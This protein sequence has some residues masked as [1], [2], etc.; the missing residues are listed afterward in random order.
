MPTI[1]EGA[2]KVAQCDSCDACF[3]NGVLC[4]EHG[5][6]DAWREETR[7]CKWCGGQFTPEDRAQVLCCEDCAEAYYS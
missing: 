5:C 2:Y 4:H 3:I 6:P 1:Q 7:E